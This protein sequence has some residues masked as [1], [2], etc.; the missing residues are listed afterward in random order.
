MLRLN[1]GCGLDK[2]PKEEGWVNID[3]RAEVEPDLVHDIAK[4]LPYEKGTVDEIFAKDIVEH[5]PW[6]QI[7]NVL[8]GWHQSLKRGG[9][10]YIQCPDLWALAT[11]IIKGELYRWEQISFWIYGEQNVNENTHKAGFT[12]PSLTMLLVEVGFK[13]ES[14]QSDGGSNIMCWA[15]KK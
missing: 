14:C 10:L 11:K 2:R 9:K 3:C 5:L 12:I 4:P 13:V 1:L 7:P 8:N 6:R 15:V